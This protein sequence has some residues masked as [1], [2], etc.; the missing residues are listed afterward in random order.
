MK[1]KMNYTDAQLWVCRHTSFTLKRGNLPISGFLSE[2]PIPDWADDFEQ[3]PFMGN[4]LLSEVLFFHKKSHTVI[5][6]DIVQNNQKIEGKLFTN[7]VFKFGGVSY[8]NGGVARDIRMIFIKRKLA[9]QSLKRFLSWDFDKLILAH[10]DCILT[11]AR[12]FVEQK[13]RWLEQ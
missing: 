4:P 5:L 1:Q 9:R 2:S 13:F 7:F 6:G 3:L 10:G 11:G 12:S 8:P